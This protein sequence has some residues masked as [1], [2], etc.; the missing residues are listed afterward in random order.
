[1]QLHAVPRPRRL[2][3]EAEPE[4]PTRAPGELGDELRRDGAPLTQRHLR[5]G[6]VESLVW[7]SACAALSP[8]A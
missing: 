8:S 2:A 3:E 4:R 5:C 6:R 1:M 7:G